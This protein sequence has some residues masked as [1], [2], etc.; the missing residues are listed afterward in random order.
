MLHGNTIN[1][2]WAAL[3]DP[4]RESSGLASDRTYIPIHATCPMTK[5][6]P[7]RCQRTCVEVVS[8]L[9][10]QMELTNIDN[11]NFSWFGNARNAGAL[12]V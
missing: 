4:M 12:L 7:L 2:P 5:A 1:R 11:I 10:A 6:F 3:I 9:D 8:K